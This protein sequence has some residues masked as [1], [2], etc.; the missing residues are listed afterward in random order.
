[1]NAA[2]FQRLLS[3]EVATYKNLLETQGGDWIV[4]GFIDIQKNIYSITKDTKVLS[5]IIEITLMPRLQAFAERNRLEI[6]LPEAQNSYPDLTF[7]DAEGHLFAVDFK[8]SYYDDSGKANGMTLGSYWGYFR[9]RSSA[10]NISHPYEEYKCHLVLGVLYKRQDDNSDDTSIYSL[11]D[12]AA[13]RSVIGEFIFFVQPKWRIASDRP[14]S[15]NT[16]NIGAIQ[17]VVDLA[18]GNGPFANLGEEIF[19]DY[20]MGFFNQADAR[21]SGIGKPKYHN[22]ETYKKHMAKNHEIMLRLKDIR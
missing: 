14:G 12:L 4:K 7:K 2:D 16:R 5:K 1:M 10:K 19:D 9:I 17:D 18:N 3:K 13:I 21:I 6:E 11:D 22:L 15:G 8:S 20:W